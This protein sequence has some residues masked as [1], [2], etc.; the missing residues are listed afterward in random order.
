MQARPALHLSTEWKASLT[1]LFAAATP[2][3]I[4]KMLHALTTCCHTNGIVDGYGALAPASSQNVDY[5]K[6]GAAGS[7]CVAWFP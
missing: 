3:D 5:V 4:S 2:D 1:Q 7:I 6:N